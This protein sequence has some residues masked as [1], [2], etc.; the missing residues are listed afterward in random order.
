MWTRSR[1]SLY[2]QI[3]FQNHQGTASIQPQIGFTALWSASESALQS[4]SVHLAQTT[5]KLWEIGFLLDYWSLI[6]AI[7]S[8]FNRLLLRQALQ[9]L[10]RA[11]DHIWSWCSMLK[12]VFV[13][14]FLQFS[15]YGRFLRTF[16]LLGRFSSF[17]FIL[18]VAGML[19]SKVEEMLWQDRVE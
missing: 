13:I 17:S 2:V 16:A 15:Q 8:V 19:S 9:G 12:V 10:R 18:V 11:R 7:F 3:R 6:E 14:V 5:R 1:V 4:Q